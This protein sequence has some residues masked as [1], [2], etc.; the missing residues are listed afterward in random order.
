MVMIGRPSVMIAG[1]SLLPDISTVPTVSATYLRGTIDYAVARGVPRRAVLSRIGVTESDLLLDE[2]RLPLENLIA[3]FRVSAELSNDPAFALHAG[4]HVPCD[5]VAIAAPM[6]QA[7][8]TVQGAL[9]QV[10]RYARLGLDFPTLG[11]GD[12]FRLASD[13]AGAWLTD[14]RPRDRWPEITESVFARI[15]RGTRR[16][17]TRDVLRAVYVTHAA[18]TYRAVY[19]EV[20]RVPI[21]F[22]SDRNALL[23]DPGYLTTTL[24][25]APAHITRILTAHADAQLAALDERRSC[26]GRVES[27][28]RPLLHDGQASIE[29]VSRELAMSRQTLYRKLKAEGVTFAQVLDRLRQSVA[30]DALR[31][32]TVSVREAARRIGF[33]DA[34]AFSRA[35]KRWTG[36]NPSAVVSGR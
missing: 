23:L 7:A 26:R 6:G 19:N 3:L 32:G 24:A 4:D 34:A 36:R 13:S 21:H 8:S 31:S 17:A 22:D 27:V 12:R 35:F 14:L 25:P 20:F 33:A 5:Q 9:Q 11:A 1:T 15:A 18:P 28:L 2:S 29:R 10:N 16:I 30:E